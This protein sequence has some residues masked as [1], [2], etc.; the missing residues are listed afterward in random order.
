M[1]NCGQ[2]VHYVIWLDMSTSKPQKTVWFPHQSPHI[3]NSNLPIKS[4]L[5]GERDCRGGGQDRRERLQK[6]NIAQFQD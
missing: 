6:S 3:S 5:C 2:S 1:Q 4:G